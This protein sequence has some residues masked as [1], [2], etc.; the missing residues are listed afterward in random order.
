[1]R[2]RGLTLVELLV[3]ITILALATIVALVIYDQ[4]LLTF[5]QGENV[6]EQQQVA[7]LGFD[8]ITS[9]IRMAGF[10][11]N[12]DANRSRPDEQVEAAY[13]TAIT[14]RADFDADDPVDSE[15][16][17]QALAGPGAAFL[18]VSTGNDEIVSFV[19]AKPDGSSSGTFTFSADVGDAVRDAS[20]EDITVG[21]ID[22]AQSDPPY[23]LFKVV[24]ENDPSG[25]CGPSFARRIPMVDNVRS[26]KFRY[27]DRSGTEL[28]PP[29]GDETPAAIAARGS[30]RRVGVE[31][32]ALTRD[33]DPHWL[34]KSDTNPL[35][36]MYRK[37][38]L[39]GEV[40]P[41]NL[42][43]GAIKDLQADVTPPSG[44]ASP[45]LYPGHC[46]GLFANW[47]PNSIQDEV[48]YYRVEYGTTSAT[49]DGAGSTQIPGLYLADLSDATPYYVSLQAIDAAGNRSP[50]TLTAVPVTTS[51]TN[52]PEGVADLTAAG[53]EKQVD[54]GWSEI[55]ENTGPTAGDPVS[56][57]IRDL[58]GYRIYR[59]SS[60]GFTPSSSNRI[61]DEALVPNLPNPV[62]ADTQATYCREHYYKVKAVDGCGLEG[63]ASG[64]VFATPSSEDD[65]LAPLDV[66][67][68]R[69][70]GNQT[71]LVWSPVRED[72][73]LHRV[74][75][76]KYK[77]YRSGKLPE[78]D[79]PPANPPYLA[80]VTNVTE[81]YDSIDIPD[82]Q[83]VH[84]RVQAVDSCTPPNESP[85]S[86]NAP[87]GCNFSG[88][89]E[90]PR[91]TY[92][93][94]VWGPTLVQVDNLGADP[95]A[96]NT[97]VELTFV[98]EAGASWSTTIGVAGPPWLF[99]WQYMW[100]AHPGS[101]PL[102]FFKKGSY[103]ITARVEQT[104]A[105]QTCSASATTRAI[106][107]Y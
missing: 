6:S 43:R 27:F 92:A 60:S 68:F 14:V 86:D 17:E 54:L 66:Q 55:D 51:N 8:I 58:V 78:A 99:T 15:L 56:P 80:E 59:G 79:P 62:Y 81:Y 93:A 74:H 33:S 91:P 35:T 32:E 90:I 67:A 40:A 84:Y 9:D 95:S 25:C 70:G 77:I 65:P 19:L 12:P 26:L 98:D 45:W 85:L 104:F 28:T 41:P 13:A 47:S 102:D 52:T 20:I 44:P 48:A 61:V 11:T 105:G 16:P 94:S 42:G 30:I 96:Q 106:L 5:K 103:S 2:E 83:A 89:V 64:E 37:Y 97:A 31:I 22:L 63:D 34:D 24:L 101:P 87:A 72:E 75:V 50:A 29:G 71:R 38:E 88:R 21:N 57:L 23:T 10:N 100:Q 69:P 49:T 107:Q 53:N 82:G 18:A 3:S 73:N 4:T 46:G 36:R 76:Q 7:R 1:M 39:G